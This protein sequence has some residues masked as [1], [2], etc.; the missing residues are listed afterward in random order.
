MPYAIAVA[1]L[2][3]FGLTARDNQV[4]DQQRHVADVAHVREEAVRDASCQDSL[5]SAPNDSIR[6]SIVDGC[7]H[8]ILVSRHVASR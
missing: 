4:N 6:A 5:R 2:A 3:L 7:V 1:V 8:R